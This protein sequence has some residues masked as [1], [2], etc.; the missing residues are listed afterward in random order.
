[1]AALKQAV[2]DETRHRYIGSIPASLKVCIMIMQLT[3]SAYTHSLQQMATSLT[4]H[5]VS[6]GIADTIGSDIILDDLLLTFHQTFN[7][8][9]QTSVNSLVRTVYEPFFKG[10]KRFQ[11][12]TCVIHHMSSSPVNLQLYAL[13]LDRHADFDI[14]TA[15]DEELCV[16]SA[17]GS[18][19]S[20]SI[21]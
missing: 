11:P 21:A 10:I 4:A 2:L 18:T 9:G 1:M 5:A 6:A 13:L 8:D 19:G 12:I 14:L 16:T 3:R 15:T 20:L 7:F 17:E